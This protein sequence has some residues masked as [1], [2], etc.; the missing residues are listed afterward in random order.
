MPTA[1]Q[2]AKATSGTPVLFEVSGGEH[3][4]W[5][6]SIDERLIKLRWAQV[7]SK[8]DQKLEQ[9][10]L[11]RM[12]AAERGLIRFQAVSSR[13]VLLICGENNCL[14]PDGKRS[15]IRN[16]PDSTGAGLQSLLN[17]WVVLNPAH[18]PYWPQIRSRGFVKIGKDKQG[19]GPTLGRLIGQR[20]Q[21]DDGTYAPRALIHCNNYDLKRERTLRFASRAFGTCTAG[22]TLDGEKGGW[23]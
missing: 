16:A 19:A 14:N 10:R 17:D 22:K 9:A 20:R 13:F 5:I 15:V 12:I 4:P 23:R 11:A 2:L 3:A 7:V 18:V 8:Y 21:Y 1:K 6:L